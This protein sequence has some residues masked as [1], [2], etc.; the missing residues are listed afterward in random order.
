MTL[1]NIVCESEFHNRGFGAAQGQLSGEVV[2]GS[3][4]N[5]AEVNPPLEIVLAHIGKRIKQAR[6]EKGYS[7]KQLSTKA[8][9]DRAYLSGIEQGKQNI[10]I[11]S[12][13]KLAGA[14][15]VPLGSIMPTEV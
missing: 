1:E 2:R 11:G 9:L 4:Q 14:L 5:G 15:E 6:R 3:S 12:A 8:G 13:L 7:Q 10:T